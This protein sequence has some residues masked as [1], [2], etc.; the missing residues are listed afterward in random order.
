[1]GKRKVAARRGWEYWGPLA[2]E[3]EAAPCRHDAFA[4]RHGVNVDT[5]RQWLY[6]LRKERPSGA[7]SSRP[8]FIEVVPA[9]RESGCV[10]VVGSTEVRFDTL[11]PAE[12]L[13]ALLAQAAH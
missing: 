1:M 2:A 4:A 7:R 3:F 6:R 11:P 5:F 9:R 12:Y 13:A 10:L 8:K